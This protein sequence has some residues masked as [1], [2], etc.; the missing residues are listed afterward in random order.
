[1]NRLAYNITLGLLAIFDT[2]C[3][4]SCGG[5][6]PTV[7]NNNGGTK[8]DTTTTT[9][10]GQNFASGYYLRNV[11]F[12]GKQYPFQVWVPA[13]Y[14]PTKKWPAIV[15]LHGGN[16]VGSDG[17]RQL[18]VGLG[19]YIAK[20]KTDFPAIAVFPQMSAEGNGVGRAAYISTVIMSLDSTIKEFQGIDQSRVYMT[21]LSWGGI[22]GFEIAFRNPTRFAAFVPISAFLCNTCIT[23]VPNTAQLAYSMYSKA[24]PAMPF[25]QF[26]GD[27]DTQ[28]P[29]D[30][31]IAFKAVYEK[32][33]PNARWSILP[34]ADHSTTY[35]IAYGTQAMWDWLWAQH[36]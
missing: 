27:K 30:E 22:Q 7:A 31:V 14:T 16:D 8:P 10:P 26:Q 29:T 1:M 11:T 2:G 6:S 21:G 19:P 4:S 32:T 15:F 5:D 3:I 23:G 9:T 36:R 20:H 35:P 17:Y 12:D 13:G 25:W 33:D 28:V 24:L 34:G 18:D